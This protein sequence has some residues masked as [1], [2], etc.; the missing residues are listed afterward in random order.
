MQLRSQT[1]L[2]IYESKALINSSILSFASGFDSR[3]K[4][5]DALETK[6]NSLDVGT[7]K[8]NYDAVNSQL[9][10]LAKVDLNLTSLK[11]HLNDT[12]AKV[13]SLEARV[14]ETRGNSFY[15]HCE[16][17]LSFILLP[18]HLIL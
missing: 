6:V 16:Y 11:E 1:T 8:A 12:N 7:L 2:A 18:L 3:L 10:N 4:T 15:S 5:I 17:F 13:L 9:G 14:S